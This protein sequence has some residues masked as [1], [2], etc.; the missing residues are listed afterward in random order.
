LQGVMPQD[1][2]SIADMIGGSASLVPP[3][4]Q[5]PV[6]GGDGQATVF[7]IDPN[8]IINNHGGTLDIYGFEDGLDVLDLRP[9]NLTGGAWD[10]WVYDYGPNDQARLEFWDLNNG[11]TIAIN[12]VGQSYFNMDM[13]DYLI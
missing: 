9:L 6:N 7:L 5:Y 4:P 8:D 11:D 1:G 3:A 13:S 2:F 10:G 12:V